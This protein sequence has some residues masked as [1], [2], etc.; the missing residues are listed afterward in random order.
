MKMKYN[1]E[2]IDMKRQP[3]IHF[4][5]VVFKEEEWRREDNYIDTWNIMNTSFILSGIHV[6]SVISR[7]CNVLSLSDE[8]GCKSMS[9][10]NYGIFIIPF[11]LEGDNSP[12]SYFIRPISIRLT[13]IQ[14][15]A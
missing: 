1:T 13:D 14:Y 15:L 2:S 8:K 3:F 5:N 7:K 9:I 4:V 10:W 12:F 6:E 11:S